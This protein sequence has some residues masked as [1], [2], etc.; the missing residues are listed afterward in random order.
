[1][2]CRTN[3]ACPSI[4]QHTDE[5]LKERHQP[6]VEPVKASPPLAGTLAVD[7]ASFIGPVVARH[8][9]ML[10]SDVVRVEADA[11]PF[12]SFSP[13]F[14]GWNQGQKGITLDLKDSSDREFYTK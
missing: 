12:R 2:P 3:G 6:E 5:V 1:M 7:L 11:D 9:A 4:G 14:N 8:L 13:M 10:G